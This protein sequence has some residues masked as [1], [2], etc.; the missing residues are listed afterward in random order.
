M[1]S[2]DLPAV[3]Q[4]PFRGPFVANVGGKEGSVTNESKFLFSANIL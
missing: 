3:L 4:A 2:R 1:G